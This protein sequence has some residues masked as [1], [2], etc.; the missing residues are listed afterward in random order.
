MPSS[1]FQHTTALDSGVQTVGNASERL[2]PNPLSDQML[3]GKT[4]IKH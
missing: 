3:S 4:E 2:V 1:A